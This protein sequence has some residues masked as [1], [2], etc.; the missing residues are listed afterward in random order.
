MPTSV[1]HASQ[2]GDKYVVIW[3]SNFIVCILFQIK[4]TKSI[5]NQ[6]IALI[7]INI[8][9]ILSA[10]LSAIISKCGLINSTAL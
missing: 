9:M 5:V 10:F 3:L 1:R 4:I 2:R 8:P 6:Q 7:F